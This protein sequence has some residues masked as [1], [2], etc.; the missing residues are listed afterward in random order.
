MGKYSNLAKT[1]PKAEDTPTPEWLVPYLQAIT[2]QQPGALA[3]AYKD[4]QARK[5][6]LA[7]EVK[8][9]NKHI[10]ALEMILTRVLD[11]QGLEQVRVQG[12]GL[13]SAVGDVNVKITDRDAVRQ[14]A[15][16]NGHERD[17]NF[18]PQTLSGIAR[19]M[20]LEKQGLPAGVELT[21]YTKV[22]FSA[23]G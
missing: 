13:V 19:T 10:M 5:A 12:G 6:E 22:R 15:R 8:D 4:A 17:L 16:D 11:E 18:N 7:A 20:A 1:L 9:H 23:K 21:P 3:V 14:W 2:T